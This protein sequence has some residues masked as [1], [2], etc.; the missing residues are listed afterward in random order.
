MNNLKNKYVLFQHKD[1]FNLF[2]GRFVSAI[3]DKVFTISLAVWILS[4]GHDDAKLHLGL[5]LA[6][7]TLP[8]VLFGPLAGTFSDKF[9]RKTCMLVADGLRFITLIFTLTL[10]INNKLEITHMYFISFILAMFVP[11]FESS[12]NAS[13]STL[14][15]KD[16][17][18][19]AIAIDSSILSMSQ[20]IGASLGGL[21]IATIHFEGALIFNATTF[22]LSFFFINRID[23]DL[24]SQNKETSYIQ[25]IIKGF[26]YVFKNKALKSLLFIF[27]F[28]NFFTASI[29]I[30]IP[31]LVQYHFKLPTAQWIGI[32]EVAFAVGT[33]TTAILLSFV[34]KHNNIYKK[35]AIALS[36]FGLSFILIG[37]TPSHWSVILIL[38][39]A[40]SGIAIINTLALGLFQTTI[41]DHMK[42]RFFAI[43]GSVAL[44]VIPISYMVTGYISAF[45]DSGILFILY[46][47]MVIVIAFLLSIIPRIQNNI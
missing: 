21:L 3:G 12:A 35:M 20:I 36:I 16:D 43:L 31:F 40:G 46:G 42:G 9:N 38:L 7:N 4:T 8:I 29:F 32:Y 41:E 10:L 37:L 22:A 34:K 24:S 6:M 1:F 27:G 44:S 14:V 5:L 19:Q 25:E 26:N 13:I 33:G 23:K 28:V 17:L 15:D 11:L 47:S 2:L 30:L 45:I 18:P 39:F